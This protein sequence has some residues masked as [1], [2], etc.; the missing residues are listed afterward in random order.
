MYASAIGLMAIFKAT[1]GLDQKK[2]EFVFVVDPLT[3]SL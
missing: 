3:F 2:D 1:R